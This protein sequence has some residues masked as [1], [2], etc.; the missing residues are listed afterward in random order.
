ML[1]AH[2]IGGLESNI[3][4]TTRIYSNRDKYRTCIA[5]SSIYSNVHTVSDVSAMYKVQAYLFD[6]LRRTFKSFL[7]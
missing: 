2:H 7:E 5:A 3:T 1:N 6:V 4:S